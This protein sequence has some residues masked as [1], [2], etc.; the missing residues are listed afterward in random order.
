M[1]VLTASGKCFPAS[2]L[3]TNYFAMKSTVVLSLKSRLTP[4]EDEG[5]GN[6]CFRG[7][8][9]RERGDG[10]GEVA[11]LLALDA[12]NP[13]KRLQPIVKS[14][15]PIRSLIYNLNYLVLS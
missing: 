5:G 11:A 3:T 13:K 14:G 10:H 4:P 2:F 7:D 15:M 8:G 6:G 12:S 1:S 9:A